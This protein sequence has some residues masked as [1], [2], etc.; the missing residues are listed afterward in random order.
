MHTSR[1]PEPA[2]PRPLRP[3]DKVRFVSPASTPDRSAVEEAAA[4]VRSWGLAVDLGPHAFDKLAYLAGTDD[5]RIADLNE[6]LR[7]PAVRAVFA[8]RGGKGSYRI[9]DRIDVE[10]VRRDPK[11]LVGFSDITALHLSLLRHGVAGGVHGALRP[12]GEGE[13]GQDADARL[14][15]LLMTGEDVVL[16]ACEDQDTAGLTNGGTARG[17][18]VGGNLPMVST[19]AGWALPPL[20]GC[21][22]LLEAVGLYL[23]EIDRQLTMLRKGGHLHGVAGVA[24]GRFTDCPPSGRLT[25]VDVLRDHLDRLAVPILGGLP[26]G[27]G[28]AALPVPL[29]M[30]TLLDGASRRLVVDR[31]MAAASP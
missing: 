4:L 8:T 31:G 5:D 25:V 7:D 12:A 13:A 27:H 10:A 28:H 22:L 9:A 16:D 21:I 15:V 24:V 19:A 26:L 30:P 17:P 20:R 23:G 14:R 18:L 3:G 2:C 11:V 29:G 1:P 6:A